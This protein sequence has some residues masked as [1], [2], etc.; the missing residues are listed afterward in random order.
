MDK[1]FLSETARKLVFPPKGILA[2]DESLATIQK[3]FAPINLESTESSRLAYRELLFSTEGI[4]KYISG[5]ILFD[6]TVW[7]ANAEGTNLHDILSQRGIL[8]GVK[9]DEGKDPLPASPQEFLTKGLNSLPERLSKYKTHGLMFTKWRAVYTIAEDLPTEEVLIENARRLAEFAFIS[10]QNGLVPIV[11]PEV[12]MDGTH[13][14]DRCEGVTTQTLTH[15]FSQLEKREVYLGGML[16]KPNMIVSGKDSDNKADASE[17]SARTL[18]VLNKCVP[19][20]VPGIV[21]LS[22]GLSPE[23]ATLYLNEINT[24]PAQPWQLSFSFGRAL[25]K[26]VLLAWAGKPENKKSAQ[27]A[28]LKRARLNSLARKGEYK[29]DMEN[30]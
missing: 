10:Q 28:F 6:E 18:R 12:L 8:P 16:L 19:H 13:S 5:V 14:I 27:D 26:P 15:V 22:G 17:V 9:V 4:E 23:F 29:E 7:Q 24:G 2:A 21:F 11:E 30:G 20:E 3:R 1:S 25:Q